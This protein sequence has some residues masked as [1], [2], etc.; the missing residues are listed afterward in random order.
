MKFDNVLEEVNGFGR[1][2][3]RTILLLV[4]PRLTLP[5]HLLLNNFIAF[6]PSHHCNS[7]SLNNGGVLRNLSLEERLIVSI[8]FDQ[9]G[10]LSSCQMFLEPQFHLLSNFSNLTDLPTVPCQNGWIYDTTTFKSTLATEWDLVCDNRRANRATATIFFIGVMVGAAVFGYISDRF[11]R[12]KTLMLS[13]IVTAFFGIA[14]AFSYN[15]PMFATMRFF[16][17]LGLSGISIISIV[18][19]IEWVDIKHRTAVSVLMSLDWSFGCALLPGVA[20]FINDWRH[21][22]AAVTSLLFPA[23]LCW[24]WLPESARWLI[25][26]GKVDTAHFYLSKCATF[27]GREEVM[28]DLKPEVLSKVILVENENRKYTQLDLVRTPGM[29]RRALLSGIVWFGLACTYYG[30]SLNISGF[31]VNIYLTQFIYGAIEIP[32]KAFIFFI[33]DKIGRRWTQAGTLIVTGLLIFCSMFIPADKGTFRTAVG[34]L[35]KMFSEGSF[36]T[37][38]LYTTELYP[39]VMRQNGLGYCSSMARAGVSVSPLIMLLEEVWVNLPSSVFSLMALGAGLSALLL[40]ETHNVH[41]PETIEDVEQP[42]R[43]SPHI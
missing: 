21:L 35:G 17:G 33:V 12:K 26:N 10:S 3:L 19:C 38:F 40:P 41:L 29:R 2:Q 32:A 31:G 37:V 42:R 9:D 4:I 16:T 39:T 23:M 15:F 5:F 24:W 7:S 14:S 6:I 43:I 1:F 36:V 34:A 13:Y 8:P 11:G 18:L 22:T 28:G 30:I 20:Y 27:N 25:S